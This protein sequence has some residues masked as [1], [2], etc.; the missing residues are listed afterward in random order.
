M[1]LLTPE[2]PGILEK[3]ISQIVAM[4]GDGKLR[5]GSDCSKE[6]CQFIQEIEAEQLFKY[7]DHCLKETFNDSGFVLQD[8][9]NEL[10]RRLGYEVENGRYSCLLYTSP[11]P[12][13]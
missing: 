2:L 3:N 9:V 13:D 6:L 11:S 8:I 1:P 12:R 7:V 4:A 10:G 5:D